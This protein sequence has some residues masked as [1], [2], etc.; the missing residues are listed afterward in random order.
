MVYDTIIVGAGS[1]GC[2][3]AA[4][5]SENPQHSVLL[6]EAGPD[7]P[8]ADSLPPEIRN[9]ARPAFT[10]DWGYR[11]EPGALGREIPLARARLVGGCSATNGTIALR[12]TPDDYD[13]WAAAGNPGWAFDDVLPFFRRL[14]SDPEGDDRWHGHAGPLPIRRD[15]A[16]A[17]LP[18]H[19]AFLQACAE[20]DF[21]PVADHNAPGAVGAGVVP[22]NVVDGVRQSAALTYL[23]AARGRR[24]LTVLADASVDRV[25][26]ESGR[27]TGVCLP[28]R[29]EPL[30]AGRVVLAA[31]AFG[32][33]AI[34]MR[35]GL[36]PASHLQEM[37]IDVVQHL[38]GVGNHLAD[39]VL[40]CLK[41]AAPPATQAMPGC[42]TMLTLR[43]PGCR[44]GHDLQ[45]FPWTISTG[46]DGRPVFELYAALMKPASQGT[47]RLAAK[48]PEQAPR[49]D[50][51]FLAEAADVERL[52]HAVRL[53]LRLAKTPPL[54][55]FA[56]QPL[57]SLPPPPAAGVAATELASLVRE[58]ARTYFH[59]VGTCR[60]G[61]HADA[62]AVVDARG[63]VHGVE[64]LFVA[65]A[66]IMPTIPAANTNLP[67]LMLAER[68][69]AW[70]AESR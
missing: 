22:R 68:F 20:A 64:G 31:G 26:F 52:A 27:A 58:K 34:L 21:P 32:S 69:A 56:L 45:V 67:T 14:E 57:F 47:L 63:R 42:Q 55:A 61:P 9:G 60:M 39:H 29:A 10:H 54:A 11:S 46:D 3:L 5:L 59:P 33:P 65:D 7:Y 48:N 37:D 53:A 12:G 28:G 24:N 8:D 51:G 18:E 36:G 50:P 23:A 43:S 19:R 16:Q 41:Y 25:L 15:S 66:S 70:L 62:G 44:R 35:S 6:L 2:V 13:E 1:A 17:L 38:P 30:R 4:R 49:I 40:V